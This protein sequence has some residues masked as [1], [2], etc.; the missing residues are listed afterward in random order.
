MVMDTYR[1]TAP[2][3]S[4]CC[5]GLWRC[6][7]S[8]DPM[9]AHINWKWN[10]KKNIEQ[11][12]TKSEI[13]PLC[14]TGI[15]WSLLLFTSYVALK[16][17]FVCEFKKWVDA[18]WERCAHLRLYWTLHRLQIANTM[19]LFLQWQKMVEKDSLIAVTVCK[20][21]MLHWKVGFRFCEF[22]STQGPFSQS[23]PCLL[24]YAHTTQ[25]PTVTHLHTHLLTL[26]THPQMDIICEH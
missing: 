18:P 23:F 8:F 6:A 16:R 11:M 17:V 7:I 22:Y 3:S 9:I 2:P 19:K 24:L 14:P 1:S 5:K 15:P 13:K 20:Q 25:T 10:E 4:L 21:V 26:H 12:N